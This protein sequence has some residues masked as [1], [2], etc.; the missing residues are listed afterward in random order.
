[1][2]VA[3]KERNKGDSPYMTMDA[4]DA[5]PIRLGKFFV[6]ANNNEKKLKWHE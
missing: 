4:P 3:K 2:L 1:M 5:M 6:A